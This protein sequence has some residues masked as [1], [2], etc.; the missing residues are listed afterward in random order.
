MKEVHLGKRGLDLSVPEP[1]N[2]KKQVNVN[3]SA[4]T[5]P[6]A[7]MGA[8]AKMRAKFRE[9]SGKVDAARQLLQTLT[10]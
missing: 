5:M 3:L 10:R 7:A 8:K 1:S 2:P 6:G 9:D 4:G